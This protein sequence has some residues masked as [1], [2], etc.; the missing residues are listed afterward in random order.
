VSEPT[1]ATPRGTPLRLENMRLVPPAQKEQDIVAQIPVDAAPFFDIEIDA[2][3]KNTI[4][5]GGIVSVDV[6]G[7]ARVTGSLG[8]PSVQ[9]DFL[10][11][12]GA[13]QYLLGRFTIDKGGRVTL[14][15]RGNSGYVD[16]DEN[17]PVTARTTAYLRPGESLQTGTQSRGGPPIAST[18]PSTEGRGTRYKITTELAG[19]FA[20]GAS[21]TPSSNTFKISPSSDPPLT[22]TEIYSLLLPRA[23]LASA[24][25]GDFSRFSQDIANNI[26]NNSVIPGL[27]TPIEDRLASTFGL[28]Q[29]SVDYSTSAPITFTLLKRLPDPLERFLITYTRSVQSGGGTRAGGQVPYTAGLLF[30][31]Y[32]LRSRPDKPVPRIQFGVFTNEQQ[33]LSG[34]LRATIA[35]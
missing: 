34:N 26:I 33:D 10:T 16:F 22:P 21:A 23:Q 18:Q 14:V 11:E 15:Y 29:F 30:E 35:Y 31:L 17:D 12:G 7:S 28:E 27:F 25:S 3:G 6:S 8:R 9:G 32:Q 4:N 13:L 5:A 24:A 2:P 1:I 20:F 19:R